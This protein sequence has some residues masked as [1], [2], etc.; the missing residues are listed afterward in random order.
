MFE[1][2]AIEVPSAPPLPPALMEMP[3]RL[4]A[5]PSTTTH[6]P[7]KNGAAEQAHH[8]ALPA[9]GLEAALPWGYPVYGVPPPEQSM[10]QP[11]LSQPV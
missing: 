5:A 8:T 4:H 9:V 11:L 7:T 3:P 6:T 1:P 10:Q 2:T